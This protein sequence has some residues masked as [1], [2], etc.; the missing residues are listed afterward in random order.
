MEANFS[1]YRI[2]LINEIREVFGYQRGFSLRVLST[3]V[4]L[5]ILLNLPPEASFSKCVAVPHQ[6]LY[7]LSRLRCPVTSTDGGLRPVSRERHR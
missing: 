3:S 2:D 6:G 4:V 7:H 5:R 1:A